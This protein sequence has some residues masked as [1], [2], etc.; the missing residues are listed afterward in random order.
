MVGK[1]KTEAIRNMIRRE[2]ISILLVQGKKMSEV[3]SKEIMKKLC[4]NEKESSVGAIGNS[5]GIIT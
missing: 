1:T 3:D 2:N 4:K 5:G